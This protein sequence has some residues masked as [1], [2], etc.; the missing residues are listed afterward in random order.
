[1]EIIS[2]PFSTAPR[3]FYMKTKVLW[4]NFTLLVIALDS[5]YR[6][7]PEKATAVLVFLFD[8]VFSTIKN[9]FPGAI[10]ETLKYSEPKSIPITV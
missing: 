2:S 10:I 5:Y 4:G 8:A 6:E 3:Y 9:D 7:L 1:M